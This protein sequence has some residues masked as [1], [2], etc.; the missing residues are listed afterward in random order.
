MYSVLIFIVTFHLHTHTYKS[1]NKRNREVLFKALKN[2]YIIIVSLQY[3][4]SF[5]F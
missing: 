4:I 1:Y 5:K 3:L 2:V